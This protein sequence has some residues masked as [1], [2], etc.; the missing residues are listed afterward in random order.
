MV[1]LLALTI[2]ILNFGEIKAE[3][4]K[5]NVK[6]IAEVVGKEVSAVGKVSDGTKGVPI[7]VLEETHSSRIGQIQHAITLNRLYEHYKMKDIALEGYLQERPKITQN[8]SLL[9]LVDWMY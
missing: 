1:L 9:P 3:Q 5:Q 8:G 6:A 2:T 4:K 7:I